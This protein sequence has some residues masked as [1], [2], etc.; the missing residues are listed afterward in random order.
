LEGLINMRVEV[1]DLN[2]RD[3]LKRVYSAHP[4]SARR[5]VAKDILH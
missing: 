1:S 5:S 4:E 3:L 2:F